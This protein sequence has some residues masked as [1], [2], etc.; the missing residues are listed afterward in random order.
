MRAV[1]IVD[2]Q[3]SSPHL[4]GPHQLGS[5]P[6]CG[7]HERLEV[8]CCFLQVPLVEVKHA[9][10]ANQLGLGVGLRVGLDGRYTC[11]QRVEAQHGHMLN[12]KIH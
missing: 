8:A 1:L 2:S 7:I 6:T 10:A 3:E 9:Q 11:S 12:H 5:C 4:L